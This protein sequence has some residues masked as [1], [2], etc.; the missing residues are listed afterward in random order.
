MVFDYQLGCQ[1]RPYKICID[2]TIHPN[3]DITLHSKDAYE[4]RS[5]NVTFFIYGSGSVK[6]DWIFDC[7]TP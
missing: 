7:E 2:Y 3:E 6:T 4:N 5:N 1:D